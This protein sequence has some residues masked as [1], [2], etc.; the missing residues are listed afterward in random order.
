MGTTVCWCYRLKFT[1]ASWYTH[2]HTS[3]GFIPGGRATETDNTSPALKELESNWR[4]K[5]NKETMETSVVS[6]A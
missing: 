6:A 4:E 1:L 2:T 3:L 5:T